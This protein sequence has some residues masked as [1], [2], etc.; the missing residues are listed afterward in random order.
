MVNVHL[1][2]ARG[3]VITGNTFG[4]AHEHDLLVEESSNVAIGTNT[5]DRNPRYFTGKDAAAHGGLLFQK[6]RDC[7]LTGL[8][9]NG[10]R[11]EPAAIALEQC[12]GFQISNSTVVDS[13]GAGFLLTEVSRSR[14]TGCTVRDGRAERKPAAS[15]K[16]N[17]G[18]GNWISQNL[19]EHGV[20]ADANA[21]RVEGNYDGE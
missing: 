20:E 6:S 2:H 15:L 17:G 13:D 9:V 4:S 16:V 19:L 11:G 1:K 8:H 14:V 12:D 5:F 3:V 7:T 21:A 18:K 10:V